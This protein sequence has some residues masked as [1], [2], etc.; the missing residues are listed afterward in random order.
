MMLLLNH[1]NSF[2]LLSQLTPL[3]FVPLSTQITSRTQNRMRSHNDAW[4]A[5]TPAM[6]IVGPF[7]CDSVVSV[8]ADT[9]VTPGSQ[10]E[11]VYAWW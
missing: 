11:Q 9:S 6:H 7:I 8:T 3:A 1:D 4:K 2:Q 10:R 5:L